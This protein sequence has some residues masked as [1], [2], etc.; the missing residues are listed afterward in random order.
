MG[1]SSG[2]LLVEVT[3]GKT[4]V[5]GARG[6]H[7]RRR[8]HRSLYSICNISFD[9]R[10]RIAI[11]TNQFGVSLAYD[12]DLKKLPYIVSTWK[13]IAAANAISTAHSPGRSG[14]TQRPHTVCKALSVLYMLQTYLLYGVHRY[15]EIKQSQ[16]GNIRQ[17][18][19][20][21]HIPYF[22]SVRNI[23][24]GSYGRFGA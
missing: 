6:C 14:I 13:A 20:A 21:D 1:W 10:T 12:E 3:G 22:C 23:A 7:F 5:S 16:P 15:I 2:G 18:R 19:S 17:T 24:T 9:R 11:Q 4:V 8:F